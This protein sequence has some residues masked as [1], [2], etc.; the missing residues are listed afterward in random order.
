[1]PLPPPLLPPTPVLVSAIAAAD[2][3]I[4]PSALVAEVDAAVT[5]IAAAVDCAAPIPSM[6]HHRRYCPEA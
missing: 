2:D 6:H 3:P 1:M 5:I 4:A